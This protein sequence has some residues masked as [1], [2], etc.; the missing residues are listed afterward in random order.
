MREKISQRKKRVSPKS[1][2]TSPYWNEGRVLKIGFLLVF[3]RAFARLI[4]KGFGRLTPVV[5]FMFC[6]IFG[7]VTLSVL[8]GTTGPKGSE[9]VREGHRGGSQSLI[10]N[11]AE[12]PEKTVR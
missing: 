7:G 4:L 5:F 6:M 9:V 11:P 3:V 1:Q 2:R 12:K 8:E 10:E